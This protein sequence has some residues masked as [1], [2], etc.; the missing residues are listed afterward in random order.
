MAAH[1]LQKN[2]FT[3]GKGDREQR[4]YL[5]FDP[6][7]A[8]HSLLSSLESVLNSVSCSILFSAFYLCI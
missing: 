3:G 4:I 6:T 5:C 2:V 1:I 7:K 8:H